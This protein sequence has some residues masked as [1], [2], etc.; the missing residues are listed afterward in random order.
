M[1]SDG[2]YHAHHRSNVANIKTTL[3]HWRQQ[4]FKNPMLNLHLDTS[5]WFHSLADIGKKEITKFS[6]P[7]SI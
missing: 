4:A 3:E 6:T 5:P 7:L 2:F 1:G